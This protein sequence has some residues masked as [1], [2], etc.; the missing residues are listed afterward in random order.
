MYFLRVDEFPA[1]RVIISKTKEELIEVMFKRFSFLDYVP[2]REEGETLL[3]QALDGFNDILKEY[4]FGKL[5]IEKA[6]TFEGCVI[7]RLF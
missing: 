3:N 1:D 4:Q 7:E 2:N 6:K 5:T